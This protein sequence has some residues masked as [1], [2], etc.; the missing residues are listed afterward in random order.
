MGHE[1]EKH[2]T[3]P[4]GR[5]SRVARG[6]ILRPVFKLTEARP[7]VLPGHLVPNLDHSHA[8]VPGHDRTLGTDAGDDVAPWGG[9]VGA[10][11]A[12]SVCGVRNSLAAG[13]SAR[14][15]VGFPRD[16][17]GSGGRPVRFGKPPPARVVGK[18]LKSP[19]GAGSAGKASRLAAEAVLESR[20]QDDG[21]GF[22]QGR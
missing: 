12:R 13:P 14:G 18:T 11:G 15:H 1:R 16:G 10:P 20:F 8:F 2:V 19:E 6:V 22:W 9:G 5:G 21:H 3:V 17:T 4:A 7:Y